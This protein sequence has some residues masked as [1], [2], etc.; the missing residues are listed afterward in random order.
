MAAERRQRIFEEKEAAVKFFAD[1]D[2][3]FGVLRE[4]QVGICK[5]TGRRK[6]VSEVLAEMRRYLMMVNG[7]DKSIRI[8]RIRISVVD[9]EKDSIKQKTVLRFESMP[10]FIKDIDKGKGVVFDFD[11]NMEDYIKD[12]D[13]GSREKLMGFVIR[14]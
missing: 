1:D 13:G 7:E 2:F 4:D 14:V 5:E 6:I 3:L 9:A 10:I 8:D 12:M 11:L